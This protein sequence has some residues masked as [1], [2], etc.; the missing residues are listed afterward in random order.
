MNTTPDFGIPEL[1]ASQ[2]NAE[3]THNEAILLLQTLLNGVIDKDLATP[4]GSPSDGDAYIVAASATGAW[5][6]WDNHITVYHNGQWK[7]I[8]GNDDSNNQITMGLRQEGA[9][10][11][12]R[13]EEKI[14]VWMGSPIAWTEFASGPTSGAYDLDGGDLTLDADGDTKIDMSHGDDVV[15]FDIGGGEKVRMH[16]LGLSIGTADANQALT[17]NGD[18]DLNLNSTF[19]SNLYFSGGFKYRENGVAGGLKLADSAGAGTQFFFAPNNAAGP[20]ATASVVTALTIANGVQVGAPT[21]GDK[22]AG[23]LNAQ[24]VYDDNVLLSCYVFDQAVDGSINLKKWDAKV[25]DRIIP[26]QEAQ[27]VLRTRT[28][29]ITEE[30]IEIADDGKHVRRPRQRK[31]I[32]AVL[33]PEEPVVD[34]NGKQIIEERR[35]ARRN[36]ETGEI[37]VVTVNVPL[38]RRPPIYDTVP[39]TPD[40]TIERRHDPARRFAAL[41][42]T[43]HDPLT[44]DGYAKYWKE[45]RHL[46]S[47]PDETNFDSVDG[48]LSIGD[49]TQRLVETVEIQA[50]LIEKLNDRIKALE[51]ASRTTAR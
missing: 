42:G 5:N 20:D 32:V 14:Y 23:T 16:S 11:W 15:A 2:A 7:F 49:W 9:R 46:P 48:Q 12:V 4:P 43:A 37:D 33:G 38:T 29:T 30:I 50:A 19:F 3:V 22:G 45:R 13:D 6:G 24:A 35:K 27:K 8:P 10:V 25:P 39:G 1:S 51:S 21:G 31:E 36:P 18:I 34:K 44:L 40:Q 17:I 47:L 41:I 26:G 28:E